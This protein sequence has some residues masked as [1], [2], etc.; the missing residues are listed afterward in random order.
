MQTRCWLQFKNGELVNDRCGGGGVRFWMW[1]CALTLGNIQSIL[2]N[3]QSTSWNIQ[4]IIC[5]QVRQQRGLGDV[6]V[7]VDGGV[8]RGRH[9]FTALAL[10]ARAVLIGRP[11]IWGLAAGGQLG[12]ERV[13]FATPNKPVSFFT[14]FSPYLCNNFETSTVLQ[15]AE[16][17]KTVWEDELCR[18]P[19]NGNYQ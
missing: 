12:V 13:M 1:K 8:R 18:I 3:I 4:S 5:H 16:I 14:A 6:E 17:T 10:G 19:L 7:Y 15:I 2:G 11:L 9:I